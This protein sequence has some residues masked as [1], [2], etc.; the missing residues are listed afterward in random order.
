MNW[1]SPV[2]RYNWNISTSAKWVNWF[3]MRTLLIN[4]TAAGAIDRRYILSYS[5]SAAL[6]GEKFIDCSIVPIIMQD[7]QYLC[8]E[9]CTL[10]NIYVW[11]PWSTTILP[12]IH[13]TQNKSI[14]HSICAPYPP[15]KTLSKFLVSM[16]HN[17]YVCITSQTS[18]IVDFI[19]SNIPL[20]NY[21]RILLKNLLKNF[22]SFHGHVDKSMTM[23][24]LCPTPWP[25]WAPCLIS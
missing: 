22:P 25:D 13:A 2:Y 9:S 11:F 18:C 14:I 1:S 19:P 10:H 17:I 3:I 21:W 23:A 12:G 4:C 15:K 8:L 6:P 7:T 5:L 16:I 20:S 24:C